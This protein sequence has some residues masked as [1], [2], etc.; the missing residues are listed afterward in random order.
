MQD[1]I[2][3]IFIL[4]ALY[5]L[6]GTLLAALTPTGADI[7]GALYIFYIEAVLI[8]SYFAKL[9]FIETL[10]SKFSLLYKILYVIGVGVVIFFVLDVLALF[11]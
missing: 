8:V 1:K 9:R 2:G 3:Q 11:I 6:A 5:W 7:F 10:K 4:I